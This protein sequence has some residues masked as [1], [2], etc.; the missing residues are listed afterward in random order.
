MEGRAVTYPLRTEGLQIDASLSMG[1]SLYAV[2]VGIIVSVIAVVVSSGEIGIFG[3]GGEHKV[4]TFCCIALTA[5]VLLWIVYYLIDWHD[6]NR[7]PFIDDNIGMKQ[8]LGYF[9]CIFLISVCI[10]FA[11]LGQINYVIIIASIYCP[12]VGRFR[13]ELWDGPPEKGTLAEAFEL[14]KDVTLSRVKTLILNGSFFF[15]CALGVA[16]GVLALLSVKETDVFIAV[17]ID[18]A[19]AISPAITVIIVAIAVAAKYQRSKKQIG[20]RYQEAIKKLKSCQWRCADKFGA[21]SA[22][23]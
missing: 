17:F 9:V 1:N 19:K 10:A 2:L 4:S 21:G 22:S 7:A 20:P 12:T 18:I 11:L 8:M 6:L 23:K 3:T 16:C 5:V 13:N 15:L 14:G